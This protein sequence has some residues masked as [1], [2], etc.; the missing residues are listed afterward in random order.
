MVGGGYQSCLTL[1]KPMDCNLPGS[2]AHGSGLPFP[3]PG[4]LSDP[5]IKPISL[6]LAG[7]F[8]FFFF[9]HLLNSVFRVRFIPRGRIS[10]STVIPS[11][12]CPRALNL[13]NISIKEILL[14]T[15]SC[16]KIMSKMLYKV[17]YH[18]IYF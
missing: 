1:C 13:H 11:T 9:P 17:K 7:E 5:G 18:V 16:D 12:S 2:S 6:A 10:E 4:T 3:S 15:Y 8:F 14:E